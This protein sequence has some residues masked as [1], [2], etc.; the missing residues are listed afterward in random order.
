MTRVAVDL[1]WSQGAAQGGVGRGLLSLVPR[2]TDEIEIVGFADPRLGELPLDIEIRWL[3]LP[4]RAPAAVWLE[5]CVPRA[6]REFRG[7]FHSPFYLLPQIRPVPSLVTLHDITFESHRHLLPGAKGWFWRHR[8]RYAS[9]VADLVVTV[10]EWSRSEIIERYQV[11]PERVLVVP[12]GVEATFVPLTPADDDPLGECLHRFEIR[13]P[14]IMTIGGAPRRGAAIAIDAW[15]ALRRMGFDHDLAVLGEPG[16]DDV[17]I[18]RLSKLSDDDYRLLL[19]GADV[20]LYP[21]EV[22][23]FGLPG[24]EAAACGTPPVCPRVGALPEVLQ[25]GAVWC[26][27][28]PLSVAEAAASVLSDDPRRESIC[29]AGFRAASRWS[30][31]TAAERLMSAYRALDAVGASRP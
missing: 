2:M 8:A 7:V 24:L 3:D 17:G 30:W 20:L 18:T 28:D 6:L 13:R 10:S 11:D 5:V 15:R 26:E 27:R 1:R 19:A 4:V 31:D 21:T 22:E 29:A 23:G 25:D 16:P 12:D 14:Y 9:R